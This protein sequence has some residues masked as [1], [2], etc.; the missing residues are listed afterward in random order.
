MTWWGHSSTT[1]E[2]GS[3]RVAT[4]PLLASRLAHLVRS[5]PPPP[6]TAARADVVLV[7]HLHYDHL[8]LPSLQA[9]DPDTTIVVPRGAPAVVPG[10]A[11]LRVLEVSPGDHVEIGGL[12]LDVLP[13]HHDGRR[14]IWSRRRA[15]AL[16]FRMTAG[17]RT[18]WYPG[19]TGLHDAIGDV[20]PVDLALV[21]IGGWGPTLGDDHL[22]PEQAAAAVGRVGA[23]WALAVH[24]GTFWPVALRTLLPGNHRRLFLDPGH[25][26]RDAVLHQEVRATALTPPFGQRVVLSGTRP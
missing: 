8:H 18:C 15:R 24:Y 9:F 14:G 17:D 12:A 23:T 21:P 11:R 16:G 5:G 25:R 13:A 22:D 7:S 2:L 10:L 3:V 1:V 19:D 4:D 6:P 26:F 20:D